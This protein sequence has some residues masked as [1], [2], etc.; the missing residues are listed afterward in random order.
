MS[1]HRLGLRPLALG[2]ALA[3]CALGAPAQ[4]IGYNVHT[5]DVWVDSRLGEINDYGLRHRDPFIDELHAHYG[6]PRPLLVDL[7]DRRGWA[8]GD[9]YYA[10]AIAHVLGIPCLDVVREY[11]RDPGQGWGAL[12]RRMGIKPG[13]DAFHA[14]KRGQVDTFGRWGRTIVVD[15][16]VR[17]DWS[18][19][20]RRRDAHDHGRGPRDARAHGRHGDGDR[21]HPGKGRGNGKGQ[22]NDK[23]R[24][25]RR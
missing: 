10:C 6:A 25:D 20:G 7:L 8:P 1:R 23:G 3:L 21:G 2:G 24:G 19:G 14:L 12:A 15:Q 17:V 9:V 13:S 16:P 11:D 5:G 4:T 18:R 22:G